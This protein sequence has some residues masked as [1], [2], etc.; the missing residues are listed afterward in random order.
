MVV[1]IAAV[2]QEW[3][4]IASL[5]VMISVGFVSVFYAIGKAIRSDQIVAWARN[6]FY[7]AIGSAFFIGIAIAFLISMDVIIL[8]TL[9]SGGFD[10]DSEG[11]SFKSLKMGPSATKA[12]FDNVVVTTERCGGIIPCQV[13]IAKSKVNSLYDMVRF[14]VA[15]KI[16]PYGMLAIASETMID[17]Q[18]VRGRPLAFA[19]MIKDSHNP[20]FEILT[21]LLIMLKAHTIF[22]SIIQNAL[23]PMFFIGGIILRSISFLRGIGGL[24]IAIS[25]GLFFVYPTAMILTSLVISPNPDQFPIVF[26]DYT[27]FATPPE[28][29]AA[30]DLETELFAWG[31]LDTQRAVTDEELARSGVHIRTYSEFFRPLKSAF[32]ANPVTY[33]VDLAVP[34]EELFRTIE[35]EGKE[36]DAVSYYLFNVVQPRGF[37]SNTAFLS[38]WVLVQTLIVVYATVIFIKDTSPFFGGDIDIAGLA[39]LL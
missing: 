34:I 6:E 1:E 37:I 39:R 23:F 38:V 35:I 16:V 17:L 27:Q 5:V 12:S 19:E 30:E 2:W 36:Y 26:E 14:Y 33:A 22:L 21:G 9:E 25:L 32:A 3:L 31:N 29:V 11:C 28:G 18:K 8:A 13:A 20:M 10:C 15:S 4:P 24:L 7:Q